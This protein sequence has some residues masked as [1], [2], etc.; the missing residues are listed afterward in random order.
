MFGSETQNNTNPFIV[1]CSVIAAYVIGS[2]CL[3]IDFIH[4]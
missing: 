1:M 4:P 3:I 2:A